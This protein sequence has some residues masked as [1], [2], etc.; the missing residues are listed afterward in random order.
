MIDVRR[1]FYQCLHRATLRLAKWHHVAKQFSKSD[2][3]RLVAKP[4]DRDVDF[5]ALGG[6]TIQEMIPLTCRQIEDC[7]LQ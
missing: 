2:C 3:A 1:K 5:T 6:M 4:V 7:P